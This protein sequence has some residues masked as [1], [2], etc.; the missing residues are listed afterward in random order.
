MSPYDLT[1]NYGQVTVAYDRDAR[2]R[3]IAMNAIRETLIAYGRYD[4]PFTDNDSAIM[5]NIFK[6]LHVREEAEVDR[7]T[8]HFELADKNQKPPSAALSSIS[9]MLDKINDEASAEV[10]PL[11][12]IKIGAAKA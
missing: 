7:G 4:K 9:G 6:L 10:A 8:E 3:S 12:K 1:N 11:G 5:D 2:L